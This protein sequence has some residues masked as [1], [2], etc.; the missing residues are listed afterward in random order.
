MVG[1]EGSP[2]SV[3]T[4]Q[5]VLYIGPAIEP[6]LMLNG[7]VN[8]K[9]S[10]T[11]CWFEYGSTESYGYVVPCKENPGAGT[12]DVWVSARVENVPDVDRPSHFRLVAFNASGTTAGKD[13]PLLTGIVDSFGDRPAKAAVATRAVI[14]NG[15][16]RIVMSCRR[17]AGYNVACLGDVQ[18]VARIQQGVGKPIKERVAGEDTYKVLVDQTKIVPIAFPAWAKRLLTRSPDRVK[19]VVDGPELERHPIKLY[20]PG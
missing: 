3:T 2:P 7:V 17:V 8:P 20:L 16:A 18:L 5:G 6:Y 11:T 15:K 10:N 14:R 19:F 9:G 1:A 4:G 13:Q 12:S